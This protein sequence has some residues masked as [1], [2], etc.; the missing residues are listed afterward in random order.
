MDTKT[1]IGHM[2]TI[3]FYTRTEAAKIL[4]VSVRT[5]Q[6]RAHLIG[7]KSV[8]HPRFTEAEIK[9]MAGGLK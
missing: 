4:R 8:G 1:T 7:K 2:A 5:I 9:A 3:R 6:K